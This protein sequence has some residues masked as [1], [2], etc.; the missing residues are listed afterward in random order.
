MGCPVCTSLGG[1][2]EGG[3]AP[4][5]WAC[6]MKI[7]GRAAQVAAA[8]HETAPHKSIV[9][10]APT[11]MVLEGVRVVY[12]IDNPVDLG[13]WPPPGAAL[14]TTPKM[15]ITPPG[16]G[17]SWNFGAASPKPPGDNATLL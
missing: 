5:E 2:A 14:V 17:G 10:A 13:Y 1:A 16:Y 9:S 12:L 3:R 7:L 6:W 4:R 8:R 15:E 11:S